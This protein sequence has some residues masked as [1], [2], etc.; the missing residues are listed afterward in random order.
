M[1][2]KI[3]CKECGWA[4]QSCD[5]Q[6]LLQLHVEV[7]NLKQQLIERENHIRNMET[8]FLS[9]AEKFP[10][11]EAAALTE[12]L[13][14]WQDKYSR[15][16]ES[17]KRV[18]KVNQNLEDKLL[19]IVDKCETEKNELL[20]EVSSLTQRLID[21]RT[22]VNRLQGEN[23]RY[24]SDVNLAIQLLQ[25]KPTNFVPQ[26]YD[27]LP[28]DL[29]QKVLAYVCGR[30]RP[31]DVGAVPIRVEMRTIKVPV[32]TSPSSSMLYP[33]DE[34]HDREQNDE[35][36]EDFIRHTDR[37][38]FIEGHPPLD[39]VSAAI[40]AKVLKER[41]RE[42]LQTRHCESCS[43]FTSV[44]PISVESST[45]TLVTDFDSA[46]YC[47]NG[48]AATTR[49][50]QGH[51]RFVD[52]LSRGNNISTQI[53]LPSRLGVKISDSKNSKCE[54]PLI[55]FDSSTEEIVEKS[56]GKT[57]ASG[58]MKSELNK[59][60]NILCDDSYLDVLKPDIFVCDI[61]TTEEDK[62]NTIR[63]NV[64]SCVENMNSVQENLSTGDC[65]VK[66]NSA[67]I[68]TVSSAKISQDC[69]IDLGIPKSD[70]NSHLSNCIT[71]YDPNIAKYSRDTSNNGGTI[72][73]F[74]Y[75]QT[76]ISKEYNRDV[77]NLTC[78]AS[79]KSPSSWVHFS[80][81]SSKRSTL[82]VSSDKTVLPT[83]CPSEGNASRITFPSSSLRGA[84]RGNE[85]SSG[86]GPRFCSMRLQAG[87]SNI[88]LDNA[89]S[90]EP[91]LYTSRHTQDGVES[92]GI[93]ASRSGAAV[94]VHA[95]RSRA[96]S[97]DEASQQH[98]KVSLWVHANST[99]SGT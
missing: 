7:E 25:C 63:G 38:C 12:E 92:W 67:P 30:R 97:L 78:S 58:D 26:K 45:Q 34:T 18:Q 1:A 19:R 43:C 77:Q 76:S 14:T 94:L 98:N 68:N 70:V 6:G 5:N 80:S 71:G 53:N 46:T 8:S 55:T 91:V 15:L 42:R 82:I 44:A 66:I 50:S 57:S 72:Q 4:C 10:N 84:M 85:N 64:S 61:Q 21:A 2:Q 9:E 65:T 59:K 17:Y 33:V 86:S 28:A 20:K 93:S 89:T 31:L 39:N 95:P 40:M 22:K 75:S 54:M 41:E 24:K 79:G 37:R 99:T 3:A 88:L 62:S 13:L 48:Y 81:E 87:T 47:L 35:E 32:S 73:Q 83:A 49:G 36:G 74:G 23:D 52:S 29:Q 69:I 11:G 60:E 90:Y 96:P 51:V 27:S 16:Y 56:R